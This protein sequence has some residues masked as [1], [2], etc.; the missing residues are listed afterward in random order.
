MIWGN[1]VA[2]LQENLKR[3]LAYSSI[4]HAGYMMVGVTAAFS[5][6]SHGGGVYYGSEG[7]FFYLV[8]YALMTLGAFGV[9]SALRIKGQVVETVD[10]LSGSG[11]D[12]SLAG[13][14]ACRFA[15]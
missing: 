5:G 12:P 6:E 4:A 15:C 2:L 10:D 9:F 7:V 3:L 13:A 1:F 8:A 14:G 11:L